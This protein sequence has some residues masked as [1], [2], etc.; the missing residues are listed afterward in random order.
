MLLSRYH[1]HRESYISCRKRSSSSTSLS[2][3]AYHTC[4]QQTLK[5]LTDFDENSTKEDPIADEGIPAFITTIPI[6]K[7]THH[8]EVKFPKLPPI[9]PIIL[10]QT[11]LQLF[12]QK[13]DACCIFCDFSDPESDIYAKSQK[14]NTLKE[15]LDCI[16][17]SSL[18]NF[19]DE[20]NERFYN[21][22]TFNLT[23]PIPPIDKKYL[24]YDDEPLIIEV[25][26]T[27][28]QYIYQILRAF[29][30]IVKQCDFY[31]TLRKIMNNLLISADPNEREE[32]LNFFKEYVK[33]YPDELD[34]I[35]HDFSYKLIE[36]RESRPIS[37]PFPV[38]PILKF[39]VEVIKN[40]TEIT[41]IIDAVFQKSVVPLISCQHIVTVYPQF[42]AVID[43]ISEKDPDIPKQVLRV[44]LRHWPETCPSKQISYFFLLNFL[45]QKLSTEDF[46]QMCQPIFRLYTRCA[47]SSQHAKVIETSFKIW[48]EVKILQMI[49]DNTKL[50]F[51]IAYPTYQKI[52]KEHW[53]AATQDA[54][55]NAIKSM[56][57]LDPFMFD[58][59]AQAQKKGQN[60][61]P[62]DDFDVQIHKSWAQIARAAAKHDKSVNLARVLAEIQVNFSKPPDTQSNEKRKPFSSSPAS[63]PNI[64]SPKTAA[65]VRF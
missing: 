29:Y 41:P 25:N 30:G 65:P 47:L 51:P 46:E 36:Y 1:G 8:T 55:L 12:R 16:N 11:S 27:H 21:M 39:F 37:I 59:L 2:K 5:P 7:H 15:I 60:I 40:S 20:T 17:P 50:I 10:D 3:L 52:M 13:C 34:S 42:M 32:I 57:D 64:I 48:S 31:H 4:K 61:Q 45:I 43:A 35:L 26:W 14:T 9:N 56:H 63:K 54:A 33:N 23:R 18:N 38:T 19:D 24:V 53:K 22:I 44:A 28:L 62:N 6:T 49:M 58:E